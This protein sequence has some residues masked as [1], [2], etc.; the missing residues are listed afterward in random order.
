MIIMGHGY[1]INIDW[2]AWY[3]DITD[4]LVGNLLDNGKSQQINM[5]YKNQLYSHYGNHYSDQRSRIGVFW[6]NDGK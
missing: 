6:T 1:T 5:W 2:V 4:T 3:N